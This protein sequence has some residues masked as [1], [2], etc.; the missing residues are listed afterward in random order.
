MKPP[1]NY[2]SELY[3]PTVKTTVDDVQATI[4]APGRLL[5]KTGAGN[6]PFDLSRHLLL[7]GSDPAADIVVA[8]S[9]NGDYIAEITYE[10]EFYVLRRLNDRDAVTVNGG[11]ITEHILVD[12]DEVGL[13]D[14]T[15][16]YR[17]PDPDRTA[18]K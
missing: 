14:R 16:V 17:A 11:N 9:A 12:G 13:A 10:G 2:P 15:F 7:V 4:P 6:P 18:D 5:D 3:D 8:G 1:R